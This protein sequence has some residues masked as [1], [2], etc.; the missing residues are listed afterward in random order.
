MGERVYPGFAGYSV[1]SRRPNLSL[2]ASFH[3]DLIAATARF[4]DQRSQ[5]CGGVLRHRSELF[6]CRLDK[7]KGA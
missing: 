4:R 1:T 7:R 3:K 5:V 6:Q 2:K